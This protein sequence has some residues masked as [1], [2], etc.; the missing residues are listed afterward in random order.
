MLSSGMLKLV[1]VVEHMADTDLQNAHNYV[2]QLNQHPVKKACLML[3]LTPDGWVC[4]VK[5]HLRF[6][7]IIALSHKKT[8]DVMEKMLLIWE[9]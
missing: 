8:Y 5:V 9:E 2:Q 1:I 7:P 6:N 4:Y 3:C